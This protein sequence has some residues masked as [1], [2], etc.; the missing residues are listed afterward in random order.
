MTQRAAALEMQ[1]EE[2]WRLG[3]Q[4]VDEITELLAKLRDRPVTPGESPA[5]VRAA[6]GND[7]LPD[8]GS[9]PEDLLKQTWQLL[10]EHSLFNGH[11]GFAGYVTSSAAPIGVL[12]DLLA[13]ALNPNAGAWILSPMATEIE[14]QTIRWIAEF[15]G[16]PATCGGLLVSGGNMSNIVGFPRGSQN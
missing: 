8:K 14:A 9:A 1:P 13:L 2:F 16:Y 11:P 3:R 5:Q 15:I 6:L 12:C 4:M 7:S 10:V